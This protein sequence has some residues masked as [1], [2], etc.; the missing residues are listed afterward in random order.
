MSRIID[1]IPLDKQ[2]KPGGKLKLVKKLVVGLISL[3]L[4]GIFMIYFHPLLCRYIVGQAY[5]LRPPLNAKVIIGGKEIKSARCFSTLTHSG[6]DA[7][8]GIVLWLPNEA[9]KDYCEV[10]IIDKERN[11]VGFPSHGGPGD[12]QLE[13]FGKVL[14]QRDK[15]R[16]YISFGCRDKGFDE[17]PKYAISGSSIKF[18]IPKEFWTHEYAGKEVQI[19]LN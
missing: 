3:C 18:K 5:A 13:C 8:D 1:K 12:Y 6:K 4:L 7:Y 9:K 15:G 19:N 16:D 14:I 11:D 2:E 17:D 10:I